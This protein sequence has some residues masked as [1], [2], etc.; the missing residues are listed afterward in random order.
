MF[1]HRNSNKIIT[2]GTPFEIN[3]TQYP[4]NWLNLS[5]AQDKIDH[6]IF[7]IIEQPRPIINETEQ[8]ITEN[9]IQF[10]DNVYIKSYSV[11]DYDEEQQIYYK[12]KAAEEFARNTVSRVQT[13]LD[14]FARTRNYDGIL[15]ACTYATSV[16][17]RFQTEGQYCVN[18]RDNTWATLYTLMEEV[19]TGTRAPLTTY[20]EVE[21]LLPV[22]EWPA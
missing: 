21:A 20:E 7:E 5:S 18:A 13:R 12:T 11:H 14:E 8:Y 19:T 17:P 3:G 10:Q 16:I 1:Y 15:S 6:E 2:E 4:S 22:L 9:D